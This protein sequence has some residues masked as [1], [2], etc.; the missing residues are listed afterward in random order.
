MCVVPYSLFVRLITSE[1]MIIAFWRSL[2]AGSVIALGLLVLKGRNSFRNVFI[3][4][5]LGWLYCLLL[6]S[7]PPA[8]VIAVEYTSVVNIV[9]IFASMLIFSSILSSIFLKERIS[10]RILITIL[11]VVM[12]LSVIL[13]GSRTV[14]I[15]GWRGDIW[16]LYVS[17]AL[18]SALTIVRHLKHIS[19]IPAIPDRISWLC[20]CHCFFINPFIN[21][22]ANNI[23]YFCHVS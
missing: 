1:P 5:K 4:G 11:V 23:Y 9:F 3:M 21:F 16:A 17:L 10:F 8:L 14:D 12:G 18:A 2:T 7:T 15:S 19:M 13:Y 22:E 6:G 20:H